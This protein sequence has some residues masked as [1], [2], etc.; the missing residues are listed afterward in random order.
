[1][2]NS[3]DLRG[4]AL[5]SFELRPGAD[6]NFGLTINNKDLTGVAVRARIGVHTL[7]VGEPDADHR[8]VVSIPRAVTSMLAAVESLSIW[9]VDADGVVT[10][11]AYGSVHTDQ[12]RPV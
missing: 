5:P 2:A 1:V 8:M 9:L 7:D 6:A 10:A 12:A 4:R 3:I 11:I